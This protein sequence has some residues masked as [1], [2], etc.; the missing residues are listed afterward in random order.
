[1]T[2]RIRNPR[3]LVPAVAVLLVGLAWLAI[4]YFGVHTLFIDEE[5]S[6]A[7]PT[8]DAAP[9]PDEPPTTV[10]APAP[11]PATPGRAAPE[12][13]GAP[14]GTPGTSAGEI[15]AAVPA[16]AEIVTEASGTFESG[17]HPTRGTA[18]VLGNGTGLID[19]RNLSL[20]IHALS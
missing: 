11:D 19:I 5:V 7:L 16:A 18:R 3:I 10:A 15:V 4:G 12:P 14:I 13:S 17:A 20:P 8:F 9:G 6:E 1:M 2:S